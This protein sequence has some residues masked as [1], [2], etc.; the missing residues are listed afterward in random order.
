MRLGSTHSGKVFVAPNHH[1]KS[2]RYACPDFCPT[3][4]Y[5]IHDF[6]TPPDTRYPFLKWPFMTRLLGLPQFRQHRVDEGLDV[7]E[8]IPRGRRRLGGGEGGA[9]ILP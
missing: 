6:C 7:I 2:T 4:L 9:H 8:S 5:I 1:V 3:Y